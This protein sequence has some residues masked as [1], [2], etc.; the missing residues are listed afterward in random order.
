MRTILSI[1]LLAASALPAFAQDPDSTN[2]GHGAAGAGRGG[3]PRPYERVITPDAKSRRG[4]LNVHRI[5]ERLFF[6]I[7]R[8]ELNKVQLLIGH[9]A[10]AGAPA[11]GR[12]G[13]TS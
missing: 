2:R 9:H 13:G 5:G 10:R 3:G 8:R 11:D 12:G 1:A 4:L 7:P 6:E